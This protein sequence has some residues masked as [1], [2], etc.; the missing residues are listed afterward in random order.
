MCA[1]GVGRAPDDVEAYKWFWLATWEHVPGA[2]AMLLEVS[3][4]LTGAQVL[5]G[6]KRAVRF[7]DSHRDDAKAA[8]ATVR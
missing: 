4:K 6:V 2:D 5:E 7:Q 3:K 8:S 1:Q